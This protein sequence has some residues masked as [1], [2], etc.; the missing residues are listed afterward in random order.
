MTCAHVNHSTCMRVI[1]AYARA[2]GAA[3]DD[4]DSDTRANEDDGQKRWLCATPACGMSFTSA[5]DVASH[6]KRSKGAHLVYVKSSRRKPF[7]VVCE[8]CAIEDERVGVDAVAYA[9]AGA[10]TD[11]CDEDAALDLD[12]EKRLADR[13]RY[14]Q[15]LPRASS[16]RAVKRAKRAKSTVSPR[17]LKGNVNMG[18]TCFMAGVLQALLATPSVANYFLAEK[19]REMNC[20]VRDC[21]ACA[22]D[23]YV[24]RAFSQDDDDDGDGDNE[25][26]TPLVP[27]DLL[28]TWW[29]NDLSFAKHAQ[30]DAHEFFLLFLE[31]I[32]AN[33]KGRSSKAMP[34]MSALG[35][36]E[37]KRRGLLQILSLAKVSSTT[38]AERSDMAS[39]DIDRNDEDDDDDGDI[40]KCQCVVHSAFAGVTQSDLICTGCGAV[41]SETCEDTIGLSLDVPFARTTPAVELLDCLNA[42][43][44]V[45]TMDNSAFSLRICPKCSSAQGMQKQMSL[46]RTPRMLVLHLKRFAARGNHG[47]RQKDSSDIAEDANVDSDTSDE[48]RTHATGFKSLVK[49]NVHVDFPLVLDVSPFC[50][51]NVKAR[52]IFGDDDVAMKAQRAHD[53]KYNYSL[54]AVIV[55]SGVL[56]GG[57]YTCYV[58]RSDG[59]WYFCDDASIRRVEIDEVLQAQ[60]YML[61][62]G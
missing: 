41:T 53:V 29:K 62:Y 34:P 54:Y 9:R 32:H 16:Y 33:V 26:A 8:A 23:H 14:L 4:G 5:R 61:F 30:Q 59:E 2:S 25:F 60:A 39:D 47:S 43:T 13:E 58:K 56:H 35:A 50:A 24:E 20:H 51:S 49:T 57:H 31:L 11:A 10:E 27:A 52:R 55:H 21:V 17:G 44:R 19:H 6:S 42:F 7:T 37:A 28:H 40:S 46:K 1:D 18:N 22:F 48:D 15:P 45:E 12:L 38:R 36:D 3:R